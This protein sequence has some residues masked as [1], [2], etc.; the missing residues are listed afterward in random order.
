MFV[1]LAFSSFSSF[2]V[3]R[4]HPW[5]TL[6]SGAKFVCVRFEWLLT[7]DI[8]KSTWQ[9]CSYSF[10]SFGFFPCVDVAYPPHVFIDAYGFVCICVRMC[11]C[12]HQIL[13]SMLDE[14]NET[15]SKI[16]RQDR[17]LIPLKT[18]VIW[19]CICCWSPCLFNIHF[20]FFFSSNQRFADCSEMY[21]WNYWIFI[22]DHEKR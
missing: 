11:C 12:Q 14:E 6:C 9:L 15:E 10:D 17:R 5:F 22:Q 2:I 3:A 13:D 16:D 8:W 18:I 20:C 19:H 1:S 21:E 4:S 7:Q